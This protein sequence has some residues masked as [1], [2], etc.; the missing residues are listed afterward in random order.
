MAGK[1]HKRNLEILKVHNNDEFNLLLR[2][3]QDPTHTT[4]P[5]EHEAYRLE[6]MLALMQAGI[7]LEK[8]RFPR[9]RRLLERDRFSLG[10]PGELS[11]VHMGT[12]SALL[13]EENQKSLRGKRI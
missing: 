8:V 7:P 10:F 9:L 6:C 11:R 12:I 13:M 5:A 2:V 3:Q 1:R 4:L